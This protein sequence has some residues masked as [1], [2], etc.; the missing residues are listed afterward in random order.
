MKRMMNKPVKKESLQ[1][2]NY[3]ED[4]YIKAMKKFQKESRGLLKDSPEYDNI[5][6]KIY[7]ELR[8]NKAK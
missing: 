5:R 1:K 3:D 8:M 2:H 4:T 7:G 6:N